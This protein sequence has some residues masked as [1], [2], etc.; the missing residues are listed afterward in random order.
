MQDQLSNI[1]IY[2]NNYHVWD[3]E[4]STTNGWNGVGNFSFI[5]LDMNI[6]SGDSLKIQ[7]DSGDEALNVDYIE[8]V[9]ALSV[10]QTPV[11]K[12]IAAGAY[13]TA[14]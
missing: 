5:T 1:S 4:F 8:C 2:L 14:V 12:G 13:H 7:F 3:A 6:N 10:P 9:S 11:R